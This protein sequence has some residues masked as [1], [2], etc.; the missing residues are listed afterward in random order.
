MIVLMFFLTSILSA[1]KNV[2][3]DGKEKVG[4]ELQMNW[5]DMMNH[6]LE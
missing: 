5:I 1:T 6:V 3:E 4:Y 2:P